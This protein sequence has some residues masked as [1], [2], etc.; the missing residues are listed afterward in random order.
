MKASAG[1]DDYLAYLWER[2]RYPTIVSYSLLAIVLHAIMVPIIS[3]LPTLPW[4]AKVVW[5]LLPTRIFLFDIPLSAFFG[6]YPWCFYHY[7]RIKLNID[8]SS[9]GRIIFCCF[10]S[11]VVM[12]SPI[13]VIPSIFTLSPELQNET[14]VAL[15]LFTAV[16]GAFMTCHYFLYPGITFRRILQEARRF[17]H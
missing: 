3:T 12:I 10:L 2:L 9:G 15:S 1:V 14:K 16:P 11:L 4:P 7:R 8:Y 17:W 6:P 5:C 13:V